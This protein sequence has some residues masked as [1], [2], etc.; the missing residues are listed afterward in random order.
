MAL[1]CFHDHHGKH[2]QNLGDKTI[3]F[4]PLRRAPTSVV[5]PCRP[6]GLPP[7]FH[8]R[9]RL[10]SKEDSAIQLQLKLKF[11]YSN[12]LQSKTN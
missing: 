2:G 12:Y 11:N 8:C 7:S 1:K 6:P 10:D 9:H 3:V 5:T 4:V